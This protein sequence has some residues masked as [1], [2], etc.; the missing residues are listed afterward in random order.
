MFLPDLPKGMRGRGE[1]PTLNHATGK[2]VAERRLEVGRFYIRSGRTFSADW[3]RR[4]CLDLIISWGREADF[5]RIR[6]RERR[7]GL[8]AN[9]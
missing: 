4:T 5:K 2:W 7:D 8:I 3:V 9:W 6:R 1:S